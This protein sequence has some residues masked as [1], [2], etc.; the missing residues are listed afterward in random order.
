VAIDNGFSTL[1]TAVVTAELLPA[2]SDPFSEFT[3]FA[4]TNQAFTDLATA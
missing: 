4:P 1:V 3:V 2:L